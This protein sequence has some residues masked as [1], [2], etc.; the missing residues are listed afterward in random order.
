MWDMIGKSRGILL[1]MVGQTVSHY[2]ITEKLGEGGMGVVYRAE[3][4]K[5]RRTVALKF[6]APDNR[7]RFLREAQ[8]AAA[9][10]HNNI[11]TIFEIDEQ[12][13]F[14]AIEFIDGSSLKEKIFARPLPLQEAFDIAQQACA[15]LHAAHEKG[16]VHRDIKPANLMLTAQGQVKIMDFGLAQLGDR[17]RITKTGSSLGTPAYMSPEQARGEPADARSDIWSFGVV[18][19]E[20]ITG[21]LPFEG[22]RDEAVL[23]AILNREPEPVTARRAG[24]PI[25]L[26][27]I[28]GKA[29]TKDPASRYQ[30]VEDML[31]DL[32]ALAGR[33]MT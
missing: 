20:M 2:R 32:R 24:L 26:E 33:P 11:C 15:G 31:L 5:L 17:T 12:H 4:T 29:L 27:R 6:L 28:I 8:A 22:E 18:L 30:H 10:N 1:L 23:L 25:E 19:Y 9:L 3:D 14:L 21:R 7:D 13:G 16:V